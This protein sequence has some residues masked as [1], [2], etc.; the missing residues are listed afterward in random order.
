[1]HKDKPENYQKP[2]TEVWVFDTRSQKRLARIERNRLDAND[3]L[4]YDI[5]RYGL[6][7]A[8]DAGKTFSYGPASAGQPYILSQLTGSYCNIPAFLDSQQ[9]VETRAD[10]EAYM[11]R[12]EGF[13]RAMDQEIEVS[14]HDAGQGVI[15]PGESLSRDELLDYLRERLNS[16]QVPDDVVFID[17]VPKTSVGKFSKKT[18][19]ERFADY[20][21]PG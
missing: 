3:R 17:E 21:L 5:V 12:L 7:T 9:P 4:N 15:A 2:G 18:L 11:A 8:D 6:V 1:M 13:A 20:A 10:I 14:R 16:W 19:R